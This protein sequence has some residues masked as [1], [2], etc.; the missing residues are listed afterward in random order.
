MAPSTITNTFYG[1]LKEKVDGGKRDKD[2]VLAAAAFL[3]VRP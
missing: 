1:F 3:V 2:F